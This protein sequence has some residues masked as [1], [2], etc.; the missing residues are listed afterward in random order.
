MQQQMECRSRPPRRR[1][2]GRPAAATLWMAVA[3]LVAGC[4]RDDPLGDAILDARHQIVLVNG[5]GGAPAPAEARARAYQGIISDLQSKS[6]GGGS[7]AEAAV[8]LIAQA[9]AGLGEIDAVSGRALRE[10]LVHV[11]S[12]ARALQALYLE[13]KALERSLGTYDAEGESDRISDE[14]KVL[15]A[16]IRQ[17]EDAL[18]RSEV[19]A[20]AIRDEAAAL[21][22]Q[23][24]E[25]RTAERNIRADVLD[26]PALER[27]AEMERATELRE[28]ADDLDRRQAMLLVDIA[29][30]GTT[31]EAIR[32]GMAADQ[33]R[34][35]LLYE[36]RARI[37]ERDRSLR[38][39]AAAARD[40]AAQAASRLDGHVNELRRVILEGRASEDGGEPRPA[41]R[42]LHQQAAERFEAAAR[43]AQK[44]N[45]EGFR[46]ASQLAA[47]SAYHALASLHR[48]HAGLLEY[49]AVFL[50]GLAETEPPLPDRDRYRSLAEELL[51]LREL[52]IGA[53]ADAYDQASS[54]YRGARVDGEA[55]TQMSELAE[56]LERSGR[57]MRG[58]PAEPE[59][60]SGAAGADDDAGDDQPAEPPAASGSGLRLE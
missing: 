10:E 21:G 36:A 58:E 47:G 13:Q 8:L 53:A 49:S 56:T 52:A 57:A 35:D 43:E 32:K 20:A 50:V 51:E 54:K 30:Q 19:A 16:Q 31:S 28:K 23:A 1:L 5:D 55:R 27:V 38:E 11:I 45:T 46:N 9:Q 15:T 2:A 17:S 29:T 37:Q 7:G 59:E 33:R 3:A 40:A 12:R 60:P 39:Q 41:A 18:S 25:L 34:V 6:R 26:R 24:D 14:V 42:D 22:R 48:Q 4:D 44:A